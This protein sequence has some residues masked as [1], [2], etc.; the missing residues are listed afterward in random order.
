MPLPRITGNWARLGA[1]SRSVETPLPRSYLAG[2]RSSWTD[3]NT[4]AVAV[5]AMRNTGDE[6]NIVL[7][8]AYSKDIDTTWAAGTGGGLNNADFLT[9][10]SDAEAD[11]WYYVHALGGK[12]AVHDWGYDKSLTAAGLLADSNV[13]AAGLTTY[14][15][16]GAVLTDSSKD[17]LEYSQRQNL[18]Y[19]TNPL[20]D[21][22]DTD[23][24]TSIQ[25]YS[26]SE[27]PPGID[28]IIGVFNL[29]FDASAK[30]EIL[31]FDH[32]QADAAPSETAAPLATL[33][34]DGVLSGIAQ[35]EFL[36]SGGSPQTLRARA[37]G[38]TQFF[39]VATRGWIDP[40]GQDD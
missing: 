17:I 4:V 30:R 35:G 24:T 33:T 37:S 40:R 3:A 5:G 18:F 26:I 25:T 7:K 14:R 31:V 34:T 39:G 23:V 10:S 8:T 22:S 16:I 9:G 6:H 28:G 19:W 36:M 12:A 1:A 13:I 11:K 21:A 38:T 20:L 2:C 27:I 15:R 32:G 29:T